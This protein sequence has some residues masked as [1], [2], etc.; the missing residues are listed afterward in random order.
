MSARVVIVDYGAGNLLS[1]RR[2][3]QHIGAEIVPAAEPAAVMAADRLVVPGVGAFGDCMAGLRRRGLVEPILDFCRRDRPFLG[4]CVGMQMM[5]EASE[6]FGEHEGLGLLRGRVAAVPAI[7]ADGR[8]HKIPHI[9]WNRLL[10]PEGI[11]WA[12]SILATTAPGA[13]AYFVHSF[14]GDPLDPGD[15]L[16]DAD[17]D[18][19]RITAAVRRGNL[20]GTQ[21]HPEKS[22]EV[23][24]GMLRAFMDP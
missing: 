7:G 12:G 9:G 24:L 1:V 3:F 10:A 21:F 15:R 5:F 19:V 2:A 13:W 22:G 14:A 11:D 20:T 18:G 23:G 6:E 8:P 17:Y 16:A 4:I